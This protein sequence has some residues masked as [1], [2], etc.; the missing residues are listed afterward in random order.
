MRTLQE[1]VEGRA[2]LTR[3]KQVNKD[4]TLGLGPPIQA[5][6][7]VVC[8]QPTSV[9]TTAS[10]RAGLHVVSKRMGKGIASWSTGPAPRADNSREV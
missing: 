6:E 9:S 1:L 8:S 10:Q 5:Q 2:C 4:L 7:P 3:G